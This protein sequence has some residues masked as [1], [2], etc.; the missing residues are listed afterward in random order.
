MEMLQGN[1]YLEQTKKAF[2]FY[3]S[4]EQEGRMELVW[5]KWYHWEWEGYGGRV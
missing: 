5:G 1:Q 4:R 2:F 3:K